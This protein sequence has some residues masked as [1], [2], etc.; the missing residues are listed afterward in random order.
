MSEFHLRPVVE[1]MNAST[2]S[3]SRLFKEVGAPSFCIA[4]SNMPPQMI[5]IANPAKRFALTP[6]GTPRRA[7]IFADYE[8]E[9]N[10]IYNVLEEMSQIEPPSG[11]SG[12][13][14]LRFVSAVVT[15]VL[16]RTVGESEDIFDGGCDRCVESDTD[17]ILL[18]TF[19]GYKACK[20][21]G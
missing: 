7:Q 9:I 4:V 8:P 6:K 15:S 13:S 5:L 12:E 19:N 16:K 3:H 17:S 2:L 1:E 10:E 14:S 20:P 11:W 18:L 21:P